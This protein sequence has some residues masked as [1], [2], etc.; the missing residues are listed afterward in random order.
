[1]PLLDAI[2]QSGLLTKDFIEFEDFRFALKK[3]GYTDIEINTVFDKYDEDSD[4]CLNT[5]ERKKMID[6]LETGVF[7]EAGFNVIVIP[8]ESES[9][10]SDDEGIA[11]MNGAASK[12]ASDQRQ[13]AE[14]EDIQELD[15]RVCGLEDGVIG[16]IGRMDGVLSRMERHELLRREERSRIIA[17][18]DAMDGN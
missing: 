5:A 18:L 14:E 2:L 17:I 13:Y 15:E 1:M 7:D 11:E 4:M 10:D 6:D 16:L 8:V 3:H 12:K 9:D